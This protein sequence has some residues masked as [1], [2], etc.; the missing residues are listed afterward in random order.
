MAHCKVTKKRNQG[1]ESSC[2]KKHKSDNPSLIIQ[3]ED[4]NCPVT[5]FEK[6]L[7][8]CQYDLHDKVLFQR[9][10]GEL[11]PILMSVDMIVHQLVK[12]Q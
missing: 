2:S 12:E 11:M 3:Q 10:K 7:A 6:Y 1:D 5:S 9:A 8:H 4:P